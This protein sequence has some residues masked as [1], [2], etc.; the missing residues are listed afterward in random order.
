MK[1]MKR[2]IIPIGCL[3]LV[4]AVAAVFIHHQRIFPP[5]GAKRQNEARRPK[6]EIVGPLVYDFGKMPQRQTATR[7]WEVKNIGDVDLI[8]WAWES[9][10]ACTI[11]NIERDPAGREPPKA[12]LKPNETTHIEVTWQTKSFV[13]QF[14]RGCTVGTNDPDRPFFSLNVKG[15]VYPID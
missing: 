9:T 10:S 11:A 2:I 6:I 12:R 5:E 1:N 8:M 4:C 15:L 13:N 3:A 7:M 14:M